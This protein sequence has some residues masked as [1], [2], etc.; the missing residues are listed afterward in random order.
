MLLIFRRGPPVDKCFGPFAS[1]HSRGGGPTRF[2]TP[3][4]LFL[5]CGRTDDVRLCTDVRL[6]LDFSTGLSQLIYES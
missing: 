6:M 2:M 3:D 1:R 4:V 5:L